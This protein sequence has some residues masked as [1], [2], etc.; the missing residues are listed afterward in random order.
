MLGLS[1]TVPKFVR[2]F[3]NLADEIRGA[4]N[5]YAEAVRDRSFPTEENVYLPEGQS[6]PSEELKRSWKLPRLQGA[7]AGI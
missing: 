7:M 4:V 1:A 5:A 2:R 6:S 3:G